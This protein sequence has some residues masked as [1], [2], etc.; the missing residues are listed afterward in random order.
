MPAAQDIKAR[1]DNGSAT[2]LKASAYH[3]QQLPE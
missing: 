2:K 1:I 3:R